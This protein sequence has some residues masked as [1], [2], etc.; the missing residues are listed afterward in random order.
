V[1]GIL[2]VAATKA[3]GREVATQ[4]SGH[5]TRAFFDRY[6]IVN[7]DDLRHACESVSKPPK[8]HEMGQAQGAFYHDTVGAKVQ[9]QEQ[10]LII[11]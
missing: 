1:G 6:N 5:K 10:R 8:R 4:I 9:W 2:Q 3:G 7:E 11:F